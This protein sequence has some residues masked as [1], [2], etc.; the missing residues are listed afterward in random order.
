MPLAACSLDATLDCLYEQ[1]QARLHCAILRAAAAMG[2]EPGHS[3]LSA[4]WQAWHVIDTQAR[5]T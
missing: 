4:A 5:S 2:V 1:A 3:L